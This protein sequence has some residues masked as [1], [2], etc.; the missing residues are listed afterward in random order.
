MNQVQQFLEYI[1]NVFK[2]WIIIHP[3][4]SAIRVRNGNKIKTLL[5]GIHFR[6][7]YFDSVFIQENRLRVASMPVQ[8][9]TSKDEKTIT[10]NGAVGYIVSDIKKLYDTLYHPTTTITNMTMSIV[11]SF[12]Y[13]KELSE[14]TP[15]S[16]QDH[17]LEELKKTDFGL[18]FSYF[19]ITNF[20]VVRT[21]RLI[22][23]KSW[24]SE[25]LQMNDK[26]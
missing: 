21:Y 25:D 1:F 20:A 15:K 24:V 4:Q 18:D 3:W 10:I 12:V 9:L 14:I 6:L 11:S 2:I 5:P 13:S 26:K 23:D 19:K 16:I 7:P 8:T 17:V 22:Q